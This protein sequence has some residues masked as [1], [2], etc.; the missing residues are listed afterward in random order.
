MTSAKRQ[1]TPAQPRRA[2]SV[3]S[4]QVKRGGPWPSPTCA[5]AIRHCRRF[6]S[7]YSPRFERESLLLILFFFLT[8]VASGCVFEPT[9]FLGRSTLDFGHW[10]FQSYQ[11]LGT[12][13]VPKYT[14]SWTISPVKRYLRNM[15][16]TLTF[17]FNLGPWA[18][19]IGHFVLLKPPQ[20]IFAPMIRML[21]AVLVPLRRC[22]DF[23]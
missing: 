3:V 11:L 4:D 21:N 1:W 19:G 7:S 14:F 16:M 2:F 5:A 13:T 9:R 8:D 22:F 15:P 20:P 17:S 6:G 18:L 12:K 10:A 23:S